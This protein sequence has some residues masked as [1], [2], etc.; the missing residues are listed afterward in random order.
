MVVNMSP[1]GRLGSGR[2]PGLFAAHHRCL[3]V[4]GLVA[5]IGLRSLL[6]VKDARLPS[7]GF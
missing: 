3:G 7:D 2:E 5:A 4:T 1:N 6:R